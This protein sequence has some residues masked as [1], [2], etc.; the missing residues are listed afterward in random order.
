MTGVD[1]RDKATAPS[2]A[3]RA[4]GDYRTDLKAD[5]LRGARIGVARKKYFGYSPVTDRLV[6]AAIADMKAQGAV[7]VDPADIPTAARLDDCELEVLLYEF[8][9]DLNAYLAAQGPAAAVHSL[10]ELIAFNTREKEREMPYFGQEILTMAEKKGPLTSPAY[11]KALTLCRS[12]ARTLGI[13]AVMTRLRLDAIVAPTGSPAWATDLVNGDHFL[14][15]SST[16]AAVAGYPS[17]TV[18][19]GFAY[20]LPVGISFIGRAWSE[21]RLIQLAYSYEQATRHRKPPQFPATAVGVR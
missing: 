3:R 19:A 6:E 2:S 13:D 18:P 10:Q 7:I 5:G 17:I 15:A 20:G 4:A 8:K 1:P 9:T 21:S 14:G 11:R 16:P 12:R